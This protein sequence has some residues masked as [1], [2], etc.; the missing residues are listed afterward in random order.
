MPKEKSPSHPAL[1][2]FGTSQLWVASTS[3]PFKK[4]RQLFVPGREP[5]PGSAALCLMR[6]LF[7]SGGT[8]FR[9]L[10]RWMMQLTLAFSVLDD[11]LSIGPIAD[12]T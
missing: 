11:L 4:N 3:C 12:W 10:S 6:T 5:L 1:K 7:D 8:W 2:A 9:N